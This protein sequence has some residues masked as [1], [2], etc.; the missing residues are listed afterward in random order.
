MEH[1]AIDLG[2]RESQICV[3]AAD[4]TI[5]EEKRWRTRQIGEYLAGRPAGTL[6]I[7][8]C[9]ESFHVADQAKALG[10]EVKVVPATLARSLG[11]GARRTKT[12]VRDARVLSEVSCR[13]ALPS[14]HI[15][16]PS[17]RQ[18]KTM[19]GMREALVASRTKWINTVRGWMRG[20]G[21]T[22]GRG[23]PETLP[24]RLCEA[25]V[26]IPP[27]V[28]RQ[29]QMIEQLTAA[30]READKELRRE[31]RHDVVCKRLMTVPGVGPV[32]AVRFVAALDTPSRFKNAHQ[33]EAYL[34]LVPGEHSSG[35][36]QCRT[37]IT[38]AGSPKTRWALVQAAWC[39]R[40]LQ[41][42][43]PLVQWAEQIE[44]RRG[45]HIATM[46]LARR[47]AGVLFAM[48]RDGTLYHVAPRD[49]NGAP[50]N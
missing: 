15:A 16:S 29:L 37:S 25:G 5:V 24:R 27:Y 50:S 28:Q 6:V 8:T 39:M 42:D 14:V 44:K 2:G 45:K 19:C 20:Q 46:A 48:W 21:I 23:A 10:Y 9:A 3:R 43:D 22:V 12:D 33:V 40:R 41:S 7:E 13:I 4:G 31:A 49:P 26:D 47:L 18:R 30:I 32:T 1:I 35:E 34:G 17:S 38:K 11:V 36:R